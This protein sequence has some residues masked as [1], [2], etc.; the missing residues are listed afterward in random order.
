M[1]RASLLLA[2]TFIVQSAVC[3]KPH[4]L[5][6]KTSESIVLDG[7]PDEAVWNSA[8]MMT[9]F[10]Q[11]FPNDSALATSQTEIRLTYD[12]KNL[13]FYAK[14]YNQS[15]D[16][17]YVTPSLKRDF[18]GG[19]N[20]MIVLN[21][22]TYQDNTNA[23]N[24]GINPWGVRR[25]GVI[26]NGGNNGGSLSNDW[27]NVWY[28]EA[29]TYDGYWV[30][31]VAIPFKTL[32]YK[33]GSK[34]WNFNFYRTDTE[35]GERSSLTPIPRNFPLVSLAFLSELIWDTPLKK[36]DPSVTLIPYVS[37]DLTRDFE[38]PNQLK[39]QSNLNVGGDAKIALSPSLN[40]DLTFNPDFSQVEV[41]EQVVNLNRFELFFPE[42]RQ[43][44]LENADLFSNFGH[45]GYA[46]TFFSRRIGIAEDTINDTRVS[47][48]ILYGARISGKLDNNWRVG[49]LNMQTE[50]KED[51]NLPSNNYTVAVLQ[52]KIFAR[53]NI[54]LIF[55]NKQSIYGS[56]STKY[57]YEPG[58]GNYFNE[59]FQNTYNRVIGIDYNIASADNKW[60]GKWVY[61]KS[62][63]NDPQRKEHAHSGWIA[64]RSRNFNLEWAH[65]Y[66]G[67]NFN[68]EMGFVR[69]T[70]FF[71]INPAMRL[72]F[73][74]SNGKINRYSFRYRNETLWSEN[75]ESDHNHNT[76]VS[77]NMTNTSGF[78]LGWENRYTYL[79]DNFD[80][81][82]TDG[83]E[84]QAGSGY[85]YN[86]IFAGY[87]SDFRKNIAFRMRIQAGQYYNGNIYRANAFM[88]FRFQPYAQLRLNVDYNK[89]EMPAPYTSADI[90]LI[91]PKLDVTFTKKLFLASFLQFNSQSENFNINTRLQWRFKPVSDLFIVY[92]DNY[93]TENM[94]GDFAFQKKNRALVLKLTYWLNL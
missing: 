16:R 52:R 70:N 4:Y 15:E 57:T 39:S 24:F 71:R 23:F 11:Q 85:T 73:Y 42:K 86:T 30:A 12:D 51:I 40:L 76:R 34:S 46:R 5:I 53:S 78:W 31:E 49:L 44:F 56:D 84:L 10:M 91:G 9:G 41:D 17:D 59:T 61:Q 18:R 69:R 22:D 62:W 88:Q 60:I 54:G 63:D 27:D 43:F 37:A 93:A 8:Q 58:P 64:Y 77:F 14:M 28:G 82:N 87:F 50:Q 55:T 67:E 48:K 3:Q 81:T 20:D 47:N 29:Q 6:E 45:P 13:Y 72:N 25:E 26:S 80:P 33:E 21:L 36:P 35:I 2:F 65:T 68:S 74:P 89:I 83:V 7:V 94:N 79:F 38:D 75:R 32:R 66:N 1:I 92:T 90:W 19:S